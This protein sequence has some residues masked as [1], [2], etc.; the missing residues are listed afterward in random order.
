MGAGADVRAVGSAGV[1]CAVTGKN[2]IFISFLAPLF[3]CGRRTCV[4]MYVHT[5]EHTKWRR[6]Y[7][8]RLAHRQ[9]YIQITTHT[10]LYARTFYVVHVCIV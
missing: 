9:R 6:A 10:Y 4:N 2:R 5:E 1:L 7:I 8:L 3:S